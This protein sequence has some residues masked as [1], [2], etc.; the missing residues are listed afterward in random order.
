MSCGLLPLTL[1][2]CSV[3]DVSC[4]A[5]VGNEMWS[6]ATNAMVLYRSV[7]DV[8]CCAGVGNDLWSTATNAMVL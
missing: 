5:G 6:A 3:C 2:C 4:H 1:W 8:S 7:C